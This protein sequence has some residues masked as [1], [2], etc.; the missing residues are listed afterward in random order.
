MRKKIGHIIDWTERYARTDMRYLIKGSFW[1]GT[2][3]VLIAISS[4][5]L[6]IAFANLVAKDTYGVYKYIMS[7]SGIIG[8]FSL[9][10]LGTMITQSIAKGKDGT[11]SKAFKLNLKW[12]V[13]LFIG[14][15]A[16]SIYY[17]I[18]DNNVFSISLFIIA[19]SLPV[20]K[21]LEFYGAYWIGKK[22]FAINTFFSVAKE[23]LIALITFIVILFY[24]S[25]VMII[26]IAYFA[27][28]LIIN[29]IFYGLVAKK[30]RQGGNNKE[31]DYE[32]IMFGKHLSLI[33]IFLNVA[34]QLDRI[35]VF[36]YLGA[37]ELAIYTFASAIPKQIRG[38]LGMVG[39]LATP[40]YAERSAEELKKEIPKKFLKSLLITVPIVVVYWIM[41]PFIYKI[42]FPQYMDAVFFSQIYSLII[43]VLG[44]TSEIAINVKRATFEKYILSIGASALNITLMFILIGKFGILGI[45]SSIVISKYIATVTSLI[46]LRRIKD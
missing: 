40:K 21:S 6:S 24:G 39:L 15:L 10:G 4:F 43:I 33:N 41:A 42:F 31:I 3:Q 29:A 26:V 34:A 20:I 38:T 8:T 14:C 46:L 16:T 27:S 25:N 37:V 18:K 12:S 36:Q 35:I 1:L 30:I 5:L 19:F 11:L 32:S 22:E 2:G 9:T 13:F 23:W 45:V 28:S 17:F 44:N 7:L